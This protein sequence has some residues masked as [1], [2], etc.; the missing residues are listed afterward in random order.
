MTSSTEPTNPPARWLLRTGATRIETHRA[1]PSGRSTLTWS[2]SASAPSST[3]SR[4]ETTRARSAGASV[5]SHR[6]PCIPELLT[7]RISM[8]R[9]LA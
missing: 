1:D 4:A 3:P 9:A 8:Q 2:T 5:S 7:P 6:L